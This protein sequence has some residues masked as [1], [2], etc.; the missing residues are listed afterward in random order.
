MSDLLTTRISFNGSKIRLIGFGIQ[1]Y[2]MAL[3]GQ[4]A[5]DS[6]KVRVAKGIGSDDVPMKPLVERY[7]RWKQKIG[8]APIRDLHGPGKTSYMG[9]VYEGRKRFEAAAAVRG[10]N[11]RLYS[12][13]KTFIGFRSAGG[14]A[15][16]L[17]NLTVRSASESSVRM[18]ITAQWARDRARANEQRAP[19]FGFSPNDVRTIA[20]AAQQ[21]FKAQVTDLAVRLKGGTGAPI[22][23]NP[24]GADSEILRK[25]A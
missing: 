3:L 20:L 25:V 9:R 1:R 15:H 11:G 5:L 4:I 10:P 23:M 13:V 6:I 19:W 14:G 17:D 12:T 16:M 21:M 24:F 8:L 22:W 7:Q 18:D 2:Q